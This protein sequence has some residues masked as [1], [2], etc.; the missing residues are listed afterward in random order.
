MFI[1]IPPIHLGVDPAE[2]QLSGRGILDTTGP[3]PKA[4]RGQLVPGLVIAHRSADV[5]FLSREEVNQD[6]QVRGSMMVLVN[7]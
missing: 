4:T 2:S 7:G 1:G 5:R 3:L 6:L